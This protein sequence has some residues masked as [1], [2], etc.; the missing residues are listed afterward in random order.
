MKTNNSKQG[1]IYADYRLR[2]RGVSFLLYFKAVCLRKPRWKSSPIGPSG[3][4][5]CWP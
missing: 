5:S 2:L 1:I 3:H 4:S